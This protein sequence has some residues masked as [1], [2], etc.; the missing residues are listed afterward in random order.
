[1]MMRMMMGMTGMG[2]NQKHTTTNMIRER[3]EIGM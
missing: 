2:R 1:M 3:D